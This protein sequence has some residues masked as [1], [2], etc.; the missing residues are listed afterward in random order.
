MKKINRIFSKMV[1][2][3]LSGTL[4][5]SSIPSYA[6]SVPSS[7]TKEEI[8]E[9]NI[10]SVVEGETSEYGLTPVYYVDE[11]GNEIEPN[12]IP[13]K[14]D[15]APALPSKFDL[16]DYGYVTSVKSQKDTGTC[17]AHAV[18]A[19]AESN[20]IMNGLA[21]KAIDL[22]E[23]H[24]TWFAQGKASTDINDPL[25]C[26]GESRGNT[27][28]KNGAYDYG[29]NAYCSRA[30]LARWSGVQLEENAPPV[31]ER[32][33]VDESLRYTS[34]GYLVNSDDIDADDRESIK[35]HLMNTGA[36][37]CSYYDDDEKHISGQYYPYAAYYNSNIYETNHAVTIVGWDDNYSKSNFKGDVPLGNGAWIIK[38]SWGDNRHIDGYFYLSYYDTSL[39]KITSFEIADTSTYNNIYQYDG[40]KPRS[41]P[42]Y[43]DETFTAANIFTSKSNETISSAAFYTNEASVPYIVSVYA[44]VE[45]G[46][47]VSGTL[48]TTQKGTIDY[49]GYHVIDFNEPVAVSKGTKFS[50][51]VTLNQI[52]AGMAIQ[53]CSNLSDCSY[54]TW[55]TPSS[56]SRWNDTI[57]KY[58]STACIKALTRSDILINSSNFPDDIFRN[59][60][61][62]FDSDSDGKLSY[63]E[64]S[65]VYN[66]NLSNIGIYDFTGIEFFTEL[67]TLNCSYN[68]VVKLDLS[69]NNSLTNFICYGCSIKLGDVMCNGFTVNGLDLSKVSDVKGMTLEN[70]S[71]IPESKTMYYT[72]NCGKNY[73]LNMTL[74]ADS[75]THSYGSWKDNG[76][77]HIK[78]CYYCNDIKSENHS[79][80]D[81]NGG[82]KQ[83]SHTCQICGGV[84]SEN[85]SFG[86]WSADKES[87]TH[88]CEICGIS[89][90]ESHLFGK[91]EPY[92]NSEH[93]EI[94]ESCGYTEK[95]S[96]DFGSFTYSDES[97]HTKS[98]SDCG[99]SIS[100]KH[101]FGEWIVSDK[102]NHIRTCTDCGYTETFE[103][104][105]NDWT[106]S[107]DDSHSRKCNICGYTENIEHGFS[108]C[109]FKDENV[110]TRI[111]D[112]CGYFVE[113]MHNFSEWTESDENCHTRTCN[114]CGYTETL[115]HEYGEWVALGGYIQS[116]QCKICGYMERSEHRFSD[117]TVSNEKNHTRTC[118]DCGYT[119]TLRHTYD[120]WVSSGNDSH[121][122]EC[123]VCGYT[124]SIE[125]SFSNWTESGE[126][127]HT[128]VCDECGQIIESEHNFTDFTSLNSENHFRICND[129]GYQCNSPH[130]FGT[131]EFLDETYHSH[132]CDECG[133]VHVSEHDFSDW[134]DNGNATQIR[135][136][137]ECEY[138]EIK[139]IEY[140]SGD[141]NSDG[142]TDSFDLVLAR[143]KLKN[144]FDNSVE[145]SAAD[146]NNDGIFDEN[147]IV[148]IRDFILGKIKTF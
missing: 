9:P 28:L 27:D 95:I 108:K 36:L 93:T 17:W 44:D 121:S 1:T 99:Y 92:S 114:D 134:R 58:S 75:I 124:Q 32:P 129:C 116:R 96:H 35:Q 62:K 130:S 49:A 4:V 139:E 68:P 97:T 46:N 136:C 19:A 39:S 40:A 143:Q 41:Y 78:T 126:N 148:L 132:S 8:P 128:R 100:S 59:Y 60:I 89:E 101:R 54:F 26:D 67:T 81:W 131:V 87:H 119:E 63:N 84:K 34:Y 23:S 120:N 11:N 20:M 109:A 88:L 106:T 90:S 10:I 38:N 140:I 53:E 66:M 74:F 5:S 13:E 80:G 94:C 64:I 104:E 141:I 56:R 77:S 91:P 86:D 117:W 51:V 47:P 79:F 43:S 103:H 138:S 6:V 72:Y 45:D 33:A 122:R 133:Y 147:D 65:K 112:D 37:M 70:S 105:Y 57:E 52:G 12:L 2:T 18:M 71:F 24:L 111:C 50:V 142:R 144:G 21:D 61:L 118:T 42:Y 7:D 25:Y 14:R 16:R 22:S 123:N 48:L 107:D 102:N 76:N 85:H 82:L 31:T 15:K 30:T 125:H 135:I 83:H 115:S 3:I 113:M 69:H 110:H 73:N 55:G 98:C 137:N 145:S 127:S 29:G 146:V